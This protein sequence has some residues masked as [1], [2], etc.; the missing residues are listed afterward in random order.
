[1]KLVVITGCAGLIGSYVTRRCLDAGYKVLGIDKMTY[2][3]N[4]NF[5]R[6]FG[7]N[8]RFDFMQA[9]IATMKTL[10]DCDY[11]INVAAE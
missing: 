11:V 2:A 10:P 9:D 4:M 8:A 6:K 5:V 7:K 3:S 1:M